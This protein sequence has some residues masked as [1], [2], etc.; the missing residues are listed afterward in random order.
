MADHTNAPSFVDVFEEL[1]AGI[2]HRKASTALAQTALA[3]RTEYEKTALHRMGIPMERAL[4][5]VSYLRGMLESGVKLNQ[6][7]QQP[8]TTPARA[9][10][11]R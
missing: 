2:L 8:A 10:G 1:D 9:A 4:E 6:R 3:L 5:R 7:R 11:S